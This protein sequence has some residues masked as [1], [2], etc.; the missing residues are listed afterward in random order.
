MSADLKMADRNHNDIT[1]FTYF[2]T[3]IVKSWPRFA[4]I[5]KSLHLQ[6][7]SLTW[8]TLSCLLSYF[9]NAFIAAK[10]PLSFTQN[11]KVTQMMDCGVCQ[12]WKNDSSQIKRSSHEQ[13]NYWAIN[14]TAHSGRR[15]GKKSKWL[16]HIIWQIWVWEI[17]W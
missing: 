1:S 12:N 11:P 15:G 9:N 4:K 8:L 3:L 5:K 10:V 14:F 17:E 16:F 2:Q 7:S 6:I 13:N